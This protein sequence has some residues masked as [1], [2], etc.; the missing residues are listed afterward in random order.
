M[1]YCAILREHQDAEE[2]RQDRNDRRIR[3]PFQGELKPPDKNII[4]KLRRKS[5]GTN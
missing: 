5:N 2:R 4:E 3:R 1:T